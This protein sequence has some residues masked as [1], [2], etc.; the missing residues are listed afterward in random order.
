MII[1]GKTLR[2]GNNIN[3]DVIIPGKYLTLLDPKEL[4]KHV[5]E[6]TESEFHR[7]IKENPILV[8]GTHFGC[9]SSREQAP[10]ALKHSG[11]A[12]IIGE[13]FA[14]I[15]FRNAINIGLPLLEC[16][17]TLSNIREG[18]C[19]SVYLNEGKIVNHT[20]N[21]VL[22]GTVLPEFILEIIKDGGL[23]EHLIKKSRVENV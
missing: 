11:A 12:C 2:L 8:V 6:G 21:K 7:R 18:D 9:G 20:T 13:S 5:M 1:K 14:R 19:V 4:A 15:F 10:L 3:T 17:N 16:K 22:Y 23:I